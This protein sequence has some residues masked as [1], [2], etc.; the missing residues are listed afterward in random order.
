MANI[1]DQVESKA[2]NVGRQAADTADTFGSMI[3]S[4]TQDLGSRVGSALS[5]FS[6]NAED[7]M[8]YTRK[9]VKSNPLQSILIAV[10]TG[11]VVGS[12][13]TMASRSRQ[14]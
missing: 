4:T 2:R 9:Y 13:L 5:D 12:V 3:E 11:A 10:A 8:D 1:N 7:Y 6:T 14:A